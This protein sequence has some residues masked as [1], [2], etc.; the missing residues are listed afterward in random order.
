MLSLAAIT[1]ASGEG[2]V[3]SQLVS[4]DYTLANQDHLSTNNLLWSP[5][6]YRLVHIL[7]DRETFLFLARPSK[8]HEIDL[9]VCGTVFGLMHSASF[10]MNFS[11][12]LWVSIW[13]WAPGEVHLT[14]QGFIGDGHALGNST[15]AQTRLF[16]P[17]LE[18]RGQEIIWPHM[19]NDWTT[20]VSMCCSERW[21]RQNK[22]NINC[23]IDTLRS[24]SLTRWH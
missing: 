13:D 16:I 19:L 9:G 20:L 6:T 14:L 15:T 8:Y 1:N 21:W 10:S 18:D 5:K 24:I 2:I 22:D 7:C 3:W 11:V 17:P 12:S 4:R 23:K